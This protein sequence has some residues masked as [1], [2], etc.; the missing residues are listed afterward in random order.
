MVDLEKRL[1]AEGK[2][3]RLTIITQNVDG[4]HAAAGSKRVIELHGS[5]YKTQCTKCG[6]VEENRDSPICEGLRGRGYVVILIV[7]TNSVVLRISG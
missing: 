4:L 1:E 7:L 6:H 2:G 3:R 5:L